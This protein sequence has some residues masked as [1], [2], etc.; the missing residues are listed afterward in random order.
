[1]ETSDNVVCKDR[2]SADTDYSYIIDALSSKSKK[3]NTYRQQKKHYYL[4]CP[5]IHL[6]RERG[7]ERGRKRYVIR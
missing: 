3:K 2:A 4:I 6:C 5:F 1:M 7:R